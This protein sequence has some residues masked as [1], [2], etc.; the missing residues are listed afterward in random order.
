MKLQE[1]AFFRH[2]RAALAKTL[3]RARRRGFHLAVEGKIPAERADM[4]EPGAAAFREERHR[5][6]ANFARLRFA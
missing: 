6:E 4:D 2:R 1:Q 5:P 3:R